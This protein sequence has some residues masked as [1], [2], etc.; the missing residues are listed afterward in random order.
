[1]TGITGRRA[2]TGLG[3]SQEFFARMKSIL[4][5]CI[6]V[7]LLPLFA[8][9]QRA[10]PITGVIPTPEVD[11]AFEVYGRPSSET[12]VI[13]V[14]GGP[15]LSHKYMI[16]NDVWERLSGGRQRFFFYQPGRGQGTPFPPRVSTQ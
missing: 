9:A 11:L 14:N 16:Q 8:A 5:Q 7:C 1:M 3:D 13:A 10:T 4:S 6:F 2:S 12:P 15:G